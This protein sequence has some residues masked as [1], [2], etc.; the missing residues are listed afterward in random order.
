MRTHPVLCALLAGLFCL[1]AADGR[2]ADRK[3]RDPAGKVLSETGTV[4]ARQDVD[5]PWQ[6]LKKGQSIPAGDLLLGMA[7]TIVESKNGAVRLSLLADLD[8]LSP[9]PVVEAAV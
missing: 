2:A 9:F 4:L 5:R 6:A 8:E 3:A 1:A 7:D